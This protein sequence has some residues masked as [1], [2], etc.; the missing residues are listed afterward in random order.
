MTSFVNESYVEGTPQVPWMNDEM[1]QGYKNQTAEEAVVIEHHGKN[2]QNLSSSVY[3]I[4][5]A[6]RSL[7]TFSLTNMSDTHTETVV[8]VE[9]NLS[10]PVGDGSSSKHKKCVLQSDRLVNMRISHEEYEYL[11]Q[12][13]TPTIFCIIKSLG[14]K[15][16]YQFKNIR[17]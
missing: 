12:K 17:F 13:E 14:R 7:D 1:N 15:A 16:S 8:A 6:N 10:S 5:N 9:S 4:E 3:D 2:Y 11:R